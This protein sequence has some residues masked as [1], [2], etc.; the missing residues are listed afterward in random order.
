MS[1]LFV[2]TIK[3]DS[4]SNLLISSSLT[5]SESLK[6]AGDF[7][8]S[9]SIKLGNA[10]TDSI[11]F[12]AD[13][14]SSI[15][16]DANNTFDLGSTSKQWRHLHVGAISAS[17]VISSSGTII[18]QNIE[19]DNLDL[20]NQTFTSITASG[21]I[22]ASAYFG[23]GSNLTGIGISGSALDV[24]NITASG[25]SMSQDGDI[26]AGTASLAH[27]N[28]ISGTAFFNQVAIGT[29]PDPTASYGFHLFSET[30]PV[31]IIEG[32]AGGGAF[33]ETKVQF[34]AR[35]YPASSAPI[36]SVGIGAIGDDGIGADGSQGANRS[37]FFTDNISITGSTPT[38]ALQVGNPA[39][40]GNAVGINTS[41]PTEALQVEGNISASG[42]GSFEHLVIVGDISGSVSASGTGSFIGG[43][44]AI[45]ATGSFGY[46]SCSTDI[47]A[48]G[49]G[50]F[51]FLTVT[52][53]IIGNVS[54]SG[55]GSFQGGIDCIGDGN[56]MSPASGAFGFISTSGDIF[57][58]GTINLSASG[59]ISTVRTASFN[60]VIIDAGAVDQLALSAS[61]DIRLDT[62]S[63]FIGDGRLLTN[64]TTSV[65]PPG[66]DKQIV[67][68][69]NGSLGAEAGITYATGSLT[70]TAALVAATHVSTSRVSASAGFE[71]DTASTSS[72]GYIS[73]SGDFSSSG[74]GFF[75]NGIETDVTATGS[76]GYI[77]CSGNI[78]LSGEING[79]NGTFTTTV[80]A[81]LLK[82]QSV[83]AQVGNNLGYR[84][85][86]NDDSQVN[87]I[88]HNTIG[89]R[90]HLQIP[91]LPVSVTLPFSASSTALV[92]GNLTVGGT[93]TI[94]GA[95]THNGVLNAAN[96]FQVGG[97]AVTATAAELNVMDGFGGTTT[98]LNALIKSAAGEIEASKAV[99][100]DSDG[101]VKTK[102][103]KK[104]TTTTLAVGDSG[105][106]LMPTADTAQVFTLPN[107]NISSGVF[108]NF[109]AGSAQTHRISCP[110]NKIQGFIL[111]VSR[112]AEEGSNDAS[113]GVTIVTNQATITLVNPVV[114]DNLQF[115]S[116][117]DN[118]YVRGYVNDTPS[119]NTV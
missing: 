44:D 92:G 10:D 65:A 4:G 7:E 70:L 5:I 14:S 33:N 51:E 106:T 82:G 75:A 73:C 78:S 38:L 32:D 80:S 83:Q 88:Q 60:H 95:T 21:T 72:F 105:T 6:V 49:T 26:I 74:L 17:G 81:S 117:G 15:L 41:Q 47:S 61:G 115:V 30:S 114:G 87:G 37:L 84:F 116:D 57:V 101:A 8:L 119:L 97:V 34:R 53:E 16:P 2:N 36:W 110:T 50:S 45:E 66:A 19:V 59:D 100:Y 76:F 71:S 42:T 64:I 22:T 109:I 107:P 31:F 118:W 91:S 86:L 111:D 112:G 28:M 90:A 98:Q 13:V 103:P 55:T 46:V 94:A 85:N 89:E 11:G 102:V 104:T 52:S 12:V 9:G 18:A 79:A 20:T 63:F 58:N 62:G 68:N 67:F 29:S 24:I 69:D 43:V 25:I 113:I 54:A 39:G 56:G 93:T 35:N 77:S 3:P 108:F 40:F 96:G 1:T 23:D 48:S 99:E 27:L